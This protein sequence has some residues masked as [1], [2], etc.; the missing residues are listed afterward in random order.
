MPDQLSPESIR[1]LGVLMEKELATPDYYPMTLNALKNG[2]NQKSS[3]DPV[4]SYGDG[5]VESAISELKRAHLVGRASG[6]GSRAAKYRHAM[7]EHL[8][9]NR[10]ERAVLAVLMLRGP[11]TAGELRS[12]T[13]RMVHFEDLDAVTS[14]LSALH[15]RED[16]LVVELPVQPGRKE[17]RW[18]HT[19]VAAPPV[20]T[21]G[22]PESEAHV[23]NDVNNNT[24]TPPM[25]LRDE[26]AQLRD[27]VD[28]LEEELARFRNQ[29]E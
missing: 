16:P 18:V 17:A 7:A 21:G 22:A 8:R 1:V 25:S 3:R 19:F 20:E 10:E 12:R 13:E 6:A 5:E 26:V 23:G 11:Q 9:V 15:S 27:R 4:V 28:R 24:P 14:L 29:F 2:C